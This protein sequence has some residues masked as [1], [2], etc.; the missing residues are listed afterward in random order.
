MDNDHARWDE[1]HR[2][3]CEDCTADYVDFCMDVVRDAELDAM[4]EREE[5]EEVM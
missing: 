5:S 3:M 2:L 1:E 4:I